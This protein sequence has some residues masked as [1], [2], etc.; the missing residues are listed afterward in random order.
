MKLIDIIIFWT[1]IGIIVGIIVDYI[2]FRI[3]HYY[4]HHH[5]PSIKTH[6]WD[7]KSKKKSLDKELKRRGFKDLI[8]KNEV[9]ESEENAK[10]PKRT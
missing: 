4:A 2:L 9:K 5:E 6:R 10:N 1:I 8:E 7:K 3:W